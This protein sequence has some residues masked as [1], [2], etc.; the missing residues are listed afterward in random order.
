M[1]IQR[2]NNPSTTAQDERLYRLTYA[3]EAGHVG[4]P[5]LALHIGSHQDPGIRRK[6][7]PNED[8]LIVLRGAIP[9]ASASLSPISFVLLLVADGM[10]GQGHG[11]TASRLASGSLVEYVFRSLSTQQRAQESLLTMLSAGVQR[12]NR[13]VYEHNQQQQTDM[14]TTMTAVLVIETTAYV[15]HVGDSRLYWYRESA[16]LTQ[17]TRDHSVV[18]ALVEAGIIKPD[19]I[20]THP[21]RNQIYRSLGQETT[22]EVDTA[23]LPLADGDILLV[24]SDGLWEMVRKQQI[25]TILTTSMPTPIDTAH[26]L[27]QAALAGGG[28]DNVSAIVAQ[29]SKV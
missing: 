14:G 13:A 2:E 7:R 19:E 9:A 18:A 15:A 29:V 27:I 21:Q 22:L 3:D 8:T 25:A 26:A 16:G 20:Y 4:Q 24:C 23:T 10:G 1:V 6:Y 12:A 5:V 11:R 28:S 17:I